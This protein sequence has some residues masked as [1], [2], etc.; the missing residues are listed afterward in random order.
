MSHFTASGRF[1]TR[2]GFQEFTKTIEAPNEDV[3]REH[4]FSQV[5]SQHGVKR[6]EMELD[7]LTEADGVEA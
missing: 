1:K 5:G 7:E 2:H 3:A 6:A 4:V